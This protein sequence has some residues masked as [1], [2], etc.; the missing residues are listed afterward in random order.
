MARVAQR[1]VEADLGQIETYDLA[2]SGDRFGLQML[3]HASRDSLVASG[4]Q[5]RVRHLM[6]EDRFS[7]DQR[8]GGHEPEQIK[9]PQ[10]HSRSATRSDTTAP[11]RAGLHRVW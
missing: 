11:Q 2:E 8:R 9:I 7:I 4:P 1:P 3:E 6:F 10:K 5:R